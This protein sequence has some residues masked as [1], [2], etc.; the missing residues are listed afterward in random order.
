[1]NKIDKI[2]DVKN[3]KT[4]K[5]YI[6]QDTNKIQEG[7]FSFLPEILDK[8]LNKVDDNNNVQIKNLFNKNFTILL[9]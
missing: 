5:I 3:I 2:E 1:M 9:F 8:F 6:L 7:R 4:D